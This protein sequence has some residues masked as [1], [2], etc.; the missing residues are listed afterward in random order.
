[1]AE[2]ALAYQEKCHSIG[3]VGRSI[4]NATIIIGLPKTPEAKRSAQGS[5]FV[6]PSS[7]AP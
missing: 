5:C 1:M 6:R 2:L 7:R 4:C 3:I